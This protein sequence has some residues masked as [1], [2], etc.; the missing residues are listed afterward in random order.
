MICAH[1]LGCQDALWSHTAL[2]LH[3]RETVVVRLT[4]SR[5]ER[6]S[7]HVGSNHSIDLTS[8]KYNDNFILFP[9]YSTDFLYL[10]SAFNFN[11]VHFAYF[12][13]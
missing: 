4:Y 9:F 12:S 2:I 1:A 5:A 8:Q 13:V 3:S 11:Q 10:M 7:L 6:T